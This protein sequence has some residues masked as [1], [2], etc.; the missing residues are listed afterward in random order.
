MIIVS[1]T[2]DTDLPIFIYLTA[3]A[4]PVVLFGFIINWLLQPLVILP[5]AGSAGYSPERAP[6]VLQSATPDESVTMAVAVEKAVAEANLA[7]R[8]E[9]VQKAKGEEGVRQANANVPVQ[10][11]KKSTRKVQRVARSPAYPDA[12]RQRN[13]VSAFNWN[14]Y[15]SNRYATRW[16]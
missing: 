13:V 8:A 9:V 15:P 14:H 6:F 12:F 5:P 16:F 10:V 2:R 4:T 3:L 7:L 1:N 11:T